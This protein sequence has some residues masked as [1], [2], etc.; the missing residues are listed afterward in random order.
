M[1]Q[2][3]SYE[4]ENYRSFY[5]RQLLSLGNTEDR[6]VT[7]LFGANSGGKSNTA[8]ALL[9]IQTMIS[10][11]AAANWTLPYQPF[12]LKDGA[13]GEPTFFKLSFIADEQYYTYEFGYDSESIVFEELKEQSRNTRKMKTVFSRSSDGTINSSAVKSGFGASVAKKTRKETLLITK[14]REDNNEYANTVF[15]LMD[16]I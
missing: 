16:S 11:S 13:D 8:K 5:T 12:L 4:I 2:L 1:T 10:N 7:A 9:L 3:L 6:S 14:A 15:E